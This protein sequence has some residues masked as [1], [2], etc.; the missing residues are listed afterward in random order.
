MDFISSRTAYIVSFTASGS[1]VE[2]ASSMK[3][4]KSSPFTSHELLPMNPDSIRVFL[5]S[6]N[7]RLAVW[8]FWTRDSFP[9]TF[10]RLGLPRSTVNRTSIYMHL[11]FSKSIAFELGALGYSMA[12]S[13]TIAFD[14]VANTIWRVLSYLAL[15]ICSG[16]SS[17][18]L[19]HTAHC[20]RSHHAK[21]PV[22]HM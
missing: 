9:A 4:N 7:F 16:H 2:E 10:P 18:F 8:P 22:G 19:N 13:R 5:Q 20:F 12:S 21:N 3:S 17:L 6:R 1:I 15:E 11:T 14:S